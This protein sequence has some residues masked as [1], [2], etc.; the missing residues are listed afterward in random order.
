MKRYKN[1]AFSRIIGSVSGATNESIN[2]IMELASTNKRLRLLEN[3]RFDLI[4]SLPKESE[5]PRD[6][7]I[8]DDLLYFDSKV[9]EAY[10]IHYFMAGQVLFFHGVEGLRVFLS[11]MLG[12]REIVYRKAGLSLAYSQ[13]SEKF[14]NEANLLIKTNAQ[15][16]G[17]EKAYALIVGYHVLQDIGYD[18]HSRTKAMMK[19]WLK[20]VSRW[21]VEE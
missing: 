12:S 11:H 18:V 8:L 10:L 2:R 21:D 9:R 7:E 13:L 6:T 5:T 14:E 1:K 15:F 4:E 3:T 17:I 19:R 16:M 20:S